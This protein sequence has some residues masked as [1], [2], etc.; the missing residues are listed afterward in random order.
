MQMRW[1]VWGAF[2]VLWTAALLVPRPSRFAPSEVVVEHAF[3]I[4][5]TLHVS[6]Y[7]LFAMMSAALPVSGRRRWVLVLFMSAHAFLTEFGQIFSE[8]R[9][10]SL[11][12]VG[13]DHI[14]IA[15]GMLC[16]WTWR[17]G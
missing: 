13:I 8:E 9:H 11:S 15:L 10:P 1:L 3:G 17:R 16:T 4:S 14:G 5:K 7:A 2:V 12:D 6:A